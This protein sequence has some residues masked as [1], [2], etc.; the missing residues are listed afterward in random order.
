MAPFADL[1]QRLNRKTVTRAM[2]TKYPVHVRFYDAL[3]IGG[4][5]LRGLSLRRSGA[6]GSKTGIG[7]CD[8]P[9]SDLSELAALR[10]ARRR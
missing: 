8:P 1:Q 9:G 6:G 2:M 5:D 4:E 3:E 10:T 7:R